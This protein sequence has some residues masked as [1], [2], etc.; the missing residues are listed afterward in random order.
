MYSPFHQTGNNFTLVTTRG[1]Y[2]PRV[3]F[4][5]SLEGSWSNWISP[6]AGWMLNKILL[7]REEPTAIDP[8]LSFR[9]WNIDIGSYLVLQDGGILS[10]FFFLLMKTDWFPV[11][12]EVEVSFARRLAASERCVIIIPS[13]LAQLHT[14]D[15][16]W[17]IG[18]RWIT[19]ISCEHGGKVFD[20]RRWEYNFSFCSCLLSYFFS[21]FIC[22]TKTERWPSILKACGSSSLLKCKSPVR[23][24]WYPLLVGSGNCTL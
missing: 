14:G 10:F 2:V 24:R 16:W 21:C 6:R 23:Q 20:N 3:R 18:F 11:C 1:H 17:P 5:I 7:S 19:G 4:A 8:A 15:L 13:W 9:L 22:Q 12:S